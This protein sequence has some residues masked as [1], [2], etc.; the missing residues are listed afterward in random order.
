MSL[1]T[2]CAVQTPILF[3]S[4]AESLDVNHSFRHIRVDSFPVR[5]DT[6]AMCSRFVSWTA[7]TASIV[8]KLPCTPSIHLPWLAYSPVFILRY[9]STELAY[10]QD[11]CWT[12]VRYGCF[13]GS[14]CLPGTQL[15]ICDGKQSL[16]WHQRQTVEQGG[17]ASTNW[18]LRPSS[19]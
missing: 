3:D 8:C 1:Y 16:V 14:V 5:A 9:T 13:G 10:S 7:C 19:F 18:Q 4:H 17:G 6:F 12:K 11:E 15:H 2:H